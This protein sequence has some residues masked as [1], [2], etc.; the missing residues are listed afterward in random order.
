MTAE[1]AILNKQG[2]A[3]A[4][5]SAVTI[6][7]S[8]V[9]LTANKL[10]RL[11]NKAPVGFMVYGNAEVFG[12]PWE[13]I[14]K[15]YRRENSSKSFSTI[16]E[17]FDDFISYIQDNFIT[18]YSKQTDTLSIIAYICRTLNDLAGKRSEYNKRTRINEA[19][20]E[21]LEFIKKHQA[22]RDPLSF[23]RSAFYSK[24]GAS[25]DAFSTRMLQIDNPSAQL[26][27]RMR[28]IVYEF[29]TRSIKTDISSG[30]VIFGYG[31]DEIFPV[32]TEARLD[33]A[34]DGLLRLFDRSTNKISPS[35]GAGVFTFAQ[36]DAAHLFMQDVS[37]PV[38]RL[39]SQSYR[40]T[41]DK[42]FVDKLLPVL[43]NQGAANADIDDLIRELNT[44][45]APLDAEI[46]DQIRS[47][48]TQ[49]IVRSIEYLSK[50]DLA[51]LA[52]SLI[53]VTGLK[54]RV[55]ID[56]ESVGG[57]VDVAVISR[58]DGFIWIKRKHYFDMGLN[59]QFMHQYDKI[60][61]TGA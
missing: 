14:A 54:R 12:V 41:F 6:G 22:V 36:S 8:K 19:S 55:S 13:I 1:V 51:T 61:Q 7:R 4:A 56:L 9:H 45:L 37:E 10:F 52:E 58:A 53:E 32:I 59:H 44:A 27:K 48:V 46:I 26:R 42:F 25:I 30:V 57:P 29:V 33:G 5:D 28:Q 24:F 60:P 31:N 47:D 3:V 11:C 18:D 21:Y 50:E 23:Q 15:K 20:K 38:Y 49:P 34:P 40:S 16:E 2:V 43:I 35:N 17:I 39:I